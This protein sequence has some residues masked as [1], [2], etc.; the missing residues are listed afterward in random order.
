MS[1]SSL[2]E[3]GTRTPPPASAPVKSSPVGKVQPY[4]IQHKRDQVQAFDRNVQ[5]LEPLTPEQLLECLDVN[6]NLF[7][8]DI[9]DSPDDPSIGGFLPLANDIAQSI[10]ARREHHLWCIYLFLTTHD[11]H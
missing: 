9:S 3:S 11:F 5:Q 8:S 10:K 6:D 7:P 2:P 1:S 4:F